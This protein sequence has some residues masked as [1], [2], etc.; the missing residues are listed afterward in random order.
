[1][2]CG[3]AW[4]PLRG[5]AARPPPAETGGRAG[6]RPRRPPPRPSGRA[7]APALAREGTP[8]T[9]R[10]RGERLRRVPLNGTTA[11]TPKAYRVGAYGRPRT[12]EKV[13][14]SSGPCLS[15]ANAD[16][17]GGQPAGSDKVFRVTLGEAGSRAPRTFGLFP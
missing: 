6:V 13:P 8:S 10:P 1:M 2:T 5:G 15:R 12:V 9:A 17:L 7:H 4:T 14:G 16:L 11:G 3:L